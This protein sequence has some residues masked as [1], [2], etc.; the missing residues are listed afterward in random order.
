MHEFPYLP[1]L[2]AM[3]SC[4][5][6]ANSL[7]TISCWRSAPAEAIVTCTGSSVTGSCSDDFLGLSACTGWDPSVRGFAASAE[8]DF[9]PQGE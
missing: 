4:R 6:L 3:R 7:R 8:R 1:L 9:Q 2:N 5:L